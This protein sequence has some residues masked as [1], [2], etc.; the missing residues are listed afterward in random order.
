[1][2]VIKTFSRGYKHKLLGYVLAENNQ[3]AILLL[4]KRYNKEMVCNSISWAEKQ[5][6]DYILVE[7]IFIDDYKNDFSLILANIFQNLKEN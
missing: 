3:N 2:K 5:N 4:P 6:D 7:T 1:M